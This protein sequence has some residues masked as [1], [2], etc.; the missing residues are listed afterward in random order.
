MPAP[1]TVVMIGASGAVGGEA[2]EALLAMPELAKLTLLNRRRLDLPDRPGLTQHIVDPLDPASYR[3]LLVGHTAAICTLG[4][5]QPTRVSKEELVRVDK[6]AALDFARACKTAGIGHFELLAS[7]A[8]DP[9]SPSH[10]L[11]TKG[12]LRDGLAAFGFERLSIFQ[13]SMIL[14]PINRYD[15]KQAV[16]LAVWPKLKPLL[17]GALQKYR[18]V[19]VETLGAAMAENLRRPG[20]GMEI[21][22]W[23]D[24][25]AL[26]GR[27]T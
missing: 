20:R 2:V 8:A 19:H 16:V 25:T 15:W 23:Q 26:T 10:Y 7:V 9:R 18:G 5:G 24:F 17:A 1:L 21:L 22:H 3:H 6:T 11:L 14:T 12:E 27:P 4:V 13:P